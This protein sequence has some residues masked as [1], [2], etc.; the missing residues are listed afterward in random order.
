MA[1][2]FD[3][4]DLILPKNYGVAGQPHDA[5]AQLRREAPV[6]YTESDQYAPF[7]AITRHADI[8]AISSKPGIFSNIEGPT[9]LDHEMLKR[10]EADPSSFGQMRTIIEMDPPEHRDFRK[11][12][13][14]FF[15]PR[16]IHRLD[17]I[18]T[19]CARAQVDKLGE[20]GET[21]F[22]ESIAQRHPL[23]VLAT[24]LG[25]GPDPEDRRE[26]SER[27]TLGDR[28]DEVRLTLFSQLV[29][30]GA[31]AVGHDLVQAVDAPGR[32]ETARHLAEVSML[33]RVH[34]DDG[35]HLTEARRVCLATLQHLMIQ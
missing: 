15:T 6:F 1:I 31:R 11:V 8:M 4:N 23:R 7:Y 20:E 19:N 28:L 3:P 21:D 33:G 26:D 27:M 34:L 13:S 32:E 5:W 25:I 30:L 2:D 17:E 9:L 35:P 22:V 10:R 24:I 14:G 16:S 12:A 18:V 29:D